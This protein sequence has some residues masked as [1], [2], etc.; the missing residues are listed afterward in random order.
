MTTLYITHPIFLE[1]ETPQGHPERADRLR[2]IESE[3]VKPEFKTLKREQAKPAARKTLELAHSVEHIAHIHEFEH[4]PDLV[5]LDADT[6]MGPHSLEA[7]LYA[8]GAALRAVDAVVTGE[9]KNAFCAVRPP[10]HHAEYNKAM[11][12]CLF[13]NAAIA[14]RYAQQQ[15]GLKRIAIIDFDVHHGNGTQ[16]IFFEDASVFYASSHQSPCYPGTGMENERGKG[17]IFNVTLAPGSGSRLF[18]EAYANHIF[19][20]L[21]TFLPDLLI[22]SSGFDAHW[23]DPLAQLELDEADFAWI[24]YELK[25]RA[26]KFCNGRIISLLEGGYDLEGL[27]LSVGAHIKGLMA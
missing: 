16:D 7:S 5:M 1:H 18:R 22:L 6:C 15:Y 14:A 23:R 9:V 17:N 13:N 20:A 21:E 19:P 4:T 24:T 2:A 25:S 27:S 26:E 3:L 11:G 12:F 8:V 10:G